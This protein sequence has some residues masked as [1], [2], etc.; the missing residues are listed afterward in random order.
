M[1]ASPL[2][3][4]DITRD[5]RAVGEQRAVMIGI[6]IREIDHHQ[7]LEVMADH[8]LVRCTDAAVKLH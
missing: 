2:R 3:S 7:P 6:T 5:L 8:Q 4:S 1:A